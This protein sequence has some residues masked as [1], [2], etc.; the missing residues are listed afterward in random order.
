MENTM[1]RIRT[2]ETIAR[3]KFLKLATTNLLMVLRRR[4]SHREKQVYFIVVYTVDCQ[5]SVD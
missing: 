3:I 2:M 4:I 5:K 1:R